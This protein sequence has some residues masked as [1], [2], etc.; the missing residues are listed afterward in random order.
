ML[1]GKNKGQLTIDFL[2][3][4]L[5]ITIM[6]SAL[7]T[8]QNN[9]VKN[10]NIILIRAQEKRIAYQLAEMINSSVAVSDGT[11]EIRFR[12]PGIRYMNKTQPMPC[13]ITITNDYVKVSLNA[14]G[15]QIDENVAIV[16]PAGINI[17]GSRCG[18][19]FVITYT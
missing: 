11:A 10:Q 14:D 8:I 5:Y 12:V 17:S 18:E 3:A 9:F 16:R 2:F 15:M 4:F 19:E 13:D 1:T 6:V 7:F